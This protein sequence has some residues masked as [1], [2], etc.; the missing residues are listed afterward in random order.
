[1][2]ARYIVRFDDICPG[3]NWPVWNRVLAIL[4]GSGVKPLLAVVPDNRDP[5]LEIGPHHPA[6]WDCVR[7][8]QSDGYSIGLHG[9]EHRYS[10]NQS[11]LIGRNNYSEF[12]GLPEGEQRSKLERGLAIFARQGVRADAWVAPA[13]SFDATTVG[14]L[15]QLHVDCISDGYSL[16]PYVAADGM[17]WVPQQLGRF[18][19]MPFGTWTVCMH[20]NGW[21]E[22]ELIQF[23]RDIQAFRSDLISIAVVKQQYR[24]RSRSVPDNLFELCFRGLRIAKGAVR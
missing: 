16:A 7:N 12:A 24:S 10:S 3:M 2:A 17:L 11:G 20:V 4:D 21:G 1:M 19:R 22:T 18:R 13:H 6:F 14:L 23:E 15:A 8:W 5:H 9:F